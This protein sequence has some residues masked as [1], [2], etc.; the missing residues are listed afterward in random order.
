MYGEQKRVVMYG[1][2]KIEDGSEGGGG[3]GERERERSVS[4]WGRK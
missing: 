1:G 4:A 2:Q 3:R